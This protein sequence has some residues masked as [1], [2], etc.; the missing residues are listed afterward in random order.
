[1]TSSPTLPVEVLDCLHIKSSSRRR[2]VG[3]RVGPDGVKVT[4]PSFVSRADVLQLLINKRDWLMQ[5][6]A[7]QQQRIEAVAAHH[8]G[9]GDQFLWLGK[10]LTLH[11]VASA[12][13]QVSLTDS[14]LM[15]ALSTRGRRPEA[16]RVRE[17]LCAWYMEQALLYLRP[18]SEAYARR[19][20]RKVAS[21][22]VKYTRS[23]WGHCTSRGELQYNWLIMAAAPEIVDYLIAH[24]VSHLRH[25]NHSALFWSQVAELCPDFLAARRWLKA[26]GH[27]LSV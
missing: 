15:V 10:P 1:M 12:N 14:G 7:L 13:N 9:N 3:I 24:E 20:G 22:G 19:I 17:L 4:K 11:V 5:K 25:H 26:H 16:E 27:T 2:S 6:L 18:R 23:K 21:V 8:Y